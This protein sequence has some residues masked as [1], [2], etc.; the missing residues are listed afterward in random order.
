MTSDLWSIYQGGRPV[1]EIAPSRVEAKP[2]TSA[3]YNMVAMEEKRKADGIQEKLLAL[4]T[5]G[6]WERHERESRRGSHRSPDSSSSSRMKRK[7]LE[8]ECRLCGLQI[9]SMVVMQ[10]HYEGKTHAKKVA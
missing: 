1:S 2:L 3:M 9:S 5:A 10:Q 4:S 6:S 8:E 7:C